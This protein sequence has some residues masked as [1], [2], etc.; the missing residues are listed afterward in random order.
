MNVKNM[1]NE[2]IKIGMTRDSAIISVKSGLFHLFGLINN[3]SNTA[4]N[5]STGRRYSKKLDVVMSD[6]TCRKHVVESCMNDEFF[7]NHILKDKRITNVDQLEHFINCADKYKISPSDLFINN[8]INA[9]V[10]I[11]KASGFLDDPRPTYANNENFREAQ[12]IL[13][14]DS[15]LDYKKFSK[16]LLK[17]SSTYSFYYCSK[18]LETAISKWAKDDYKVF[19]KEIISSAKSKKK[20]VRQAIYCGAIMSGN[21]DRRLIRRVRSDASEQTSV[22]CVKKLFTYKNA[23]SNFSELIMYLT[24]TNHYAVANYLSDTLPINSLS[25]LMGTKFSGIKNHIQRRIQEAE[26]EKEANENG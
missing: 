17:Y 7:I 1:Y 2:F 22:E 20:E 25:S 5:W 15:T 13:K 18:T 3:D 26:E 24:D 14:Y 19:Y 12:A 21:A 23:Y 8:V 10:K 6:D 16:E 9:R 4:S 11:L